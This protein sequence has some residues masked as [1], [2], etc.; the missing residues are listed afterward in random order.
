MQFNETTNLTGLIQDCETLT[1]L[2][3]AQ[4]SGNANRLKEFTRLMNKAVRKVHTMILASQ[5]EWDFDDSNQTDFPI[6]TADTVASQQDYSLPTSLKIKRLEITYDGTNWVRANPLDINEV[7][8]P[9]DTTS[10]ANNFDQGK[11][12]YDLQ[13]QS[14]FLYPIPDT[15]VTGGLK[16][17]IS[18]DISEFASTD[19]TKEP[20]FDAAF[21]PMVSLLA[22]AEWGLAKGKANAGSLL[23]L[24]GDMELRLKQYYG[25]KQK[26]RNIVLKPNSI[27][28][29]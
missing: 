18:R 17:W 7:S 8:D 24:A 21:H 11:P 28:Y 16:I 29:N 26:D 15:S 22:S 27:D 1:G 12:F 25:S 23:Q 4:I 3:V 19:T 6:L 2:G 14:L 9:T 5:D 13:G 10:I 20:G